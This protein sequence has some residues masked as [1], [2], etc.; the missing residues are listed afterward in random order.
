MKYLLLL[1]G[2][3]IGVQATS[4]EYDWAHALG[5]VDEDRARTMVVDP[6]GNSYTIGHFTGTV[7]FDPSGNVFNLTSNG[8][9]D[10]F[11]LKLD[12]EGEFLWAKSIGGTFWEQGGDIALIGNELIIT[13]FYY[14]TV[15]FDPGAGVSTITAVANNDVF[16]LKLDLDGNFIWA[17]SVG[18]DGGERGTSVSVDSQGNILI[19]GYFNLEMD[20]DPGS[21]VFTLPV[22]GSEDMFVLKLTPDG[23]F[24]WAKAMGGVSLDLALAVSLDSEDNVYTTGRFQGTVDF[25]PS[26]G[27]E[28]LSSEGASDTFVV[29]LDAAGAFVWALSF[30]GLLTET[31]NDITTDADDHLLIVGH[32]DDMVDFDPGPDEFF[33]TSAGAADIYLLKLDSDGVFQW[34]RTMGGPNG[35]FG[36]GVDL[37]PF[38]DLYVA[39]NFR[40]E[41]DF[42]PGAGS[43]MLTSFGDSDVF[44][45]KLDSNGDFIWAY[46]LGGT[47]QD[48]CLDVVVDTD[49]HV[50]TMGYF[51]GTADFDPGSG[52]IE[53]TSNGDDDIFVSKVQESGLGIEES[54]AELQAIVYPNPAKESIQI[55]WPEPTI[56]S[57]YFTDTLGRLIQR[58]TQENSEQFTIPLTMPS[59]V[60]LLELK[61][62]KTTQVHKIVV[63]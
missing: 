4:Q 26:A 17:K 39:G 44:S 43:F 50:F 3:I 46:Q 32:F 19:V 45:V 24:V 40:D 41:A 1:L 58:G 36:W 63:Q 53:L 22:V 18:G 54:S 10:L 2:I 27:V 30:G 55:R 48:T 60:Y 9:R 20:F 13:G 62:N 21:G 49:G 47:D 33:V 51:T 14:N 37:G 12:S 6:V 52:M 56:F 11:I 15:D 28:E 34:V 23:D 16:V 29:K 5:S 59:G 38:G 31:S 8:N 25:D 57:W 7:D 61:V 42:D 35:D